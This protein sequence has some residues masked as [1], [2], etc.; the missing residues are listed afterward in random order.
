MLEMVKGKYTP[1][2]LPYVPIR[3]SYFMPNK[4]GNLGE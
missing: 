2:T 4:H 3:S 1:E